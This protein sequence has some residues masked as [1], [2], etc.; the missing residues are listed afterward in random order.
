MQAYNTAEKGV[1]KRGEA[2]VGTA[3]LA[4]RVYNNPWRRAIERRLQVINS[5][6]L[7]FFKLNRDEWA[8]LSVEASGKRV[9]PVGY[10]ETKDKS[11]VVLTF[12]LRAFG[13]YKDTHVIMYVSSQRSKKRPYQAQRM[14]RRMLKVAEKFK[15]DKVF[16][17]FAEK[18]ATIGAFKILKQELG[19]YIARS[20]EELKNQLAR[21]FFKRFK[22]LL[23]HLGRAVEGGRGRIYG[24]LAVLAGIL[25]RA[26]RM[27]GVKIPEEVFEELYVAAKKHGY[28]DPGALMDTII[29]SKGVDPSLL[30]GRGE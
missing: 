14:V 9:N 23:T 20:V 29:L 8:K 4:E 25:A 26:C 5:V 30:T 1:E 16:V 18:G 6:A 12:R 7:R 17:V 27:L 19:A 13:G 11:I 24:A 21:Y 3:A 10:W 15:G 28:A 2:G 22:G